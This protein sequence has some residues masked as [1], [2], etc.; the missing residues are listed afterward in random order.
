MARTL[1]DFME[2]WGNLLGIAE[3]PEET[4]PFPRSTEFIFARVQEYPDLKL[5]RDQTIVKVRSHGK[6][7]LLTELG[8]QL[9]ISQLQRS[10]AK[11]GYDGRDEGDSPSRMVIA[12]NVYKNLA[13]RL[14]TKNTP[15]P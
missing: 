12:M 5:D 10:L 9:R 11:A 14:A 4:D 1:E 3:I 7:E 8:V 13:D 2:N 6:T 15:R